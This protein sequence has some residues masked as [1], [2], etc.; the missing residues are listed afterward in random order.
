VTAT[1]SEYL[2][3]GITFSCVSAKPPLRFSKFSG[4]MRRKGN[5]ILFHDSEFI[6]FFERAIY[7]KQAYLHCVH[8][9][10]SSN[11]KY[12]VLKTSDRLLESTQH[13]SHDL[14]AY[15]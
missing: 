6:S 1:N 9:L 14:Q 15:S 4:V 5:V 13:D 11:R 2:S 12:I 8:R 7:L 10:S 3:S